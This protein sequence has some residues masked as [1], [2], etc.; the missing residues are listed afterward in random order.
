MVVL[1]VAAAAIG[2]AI[3]STLAHRSTT[4]SPSSFALFPPSSSASS[5]SADATRISGPVIPA[6]VDVNTTLGLQNG[7]AA[8]TGM[9]ITASG[10]VLTN[11]HVVDGA[12]KVSVQIAGTGPTYT[13]KVLGTDA[14]DDVAL[15]QVQGA[16]GLKTVQLGDSSKVAVGDEVVAIGN[17]LGLP[18][19]PSVTQGSVTGID[20]S[21]T[22]SDA[23]E[24]TP[25]T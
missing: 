24:A 22:A 3:G 7:A 8:G 23:G 1:A 19:P 25:R 16:S 6:V 9:V 5:G 18:G 20:Q 17:A 10:E 2:A 21:I 15:L 14:S 13:A 4:A 12:T 11:N